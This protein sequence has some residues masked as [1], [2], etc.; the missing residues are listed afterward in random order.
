MD[1]KQILS[2]LRWEREDIEKAILCLER[3][4]RPGTGTAET[5]SAA[6]QPVIE[7]G[8]IKKPDDAS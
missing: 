4:D 7:I 5:A 1:V 6:A 2:E 3:S 8:S